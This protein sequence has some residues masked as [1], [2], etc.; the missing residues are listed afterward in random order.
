MAQRPKKATRT[1]NP[2]KTRSLIINAALSLFQ[3]QGFTETSISDIV[4]KA[5]LTK[6]AFYHHFDT[7]E[8]ILL[9][10]HDE[11]IEHQL[12]EARQILEDHDDPKEQLVLMIHSMINAIDKYNANVAIFFQERRFLQGKSFKHV[13]RDRDELG[14]LFRGIVARGVE[15]GVFRKSIDPAI[16]TFGILG[17]C[18]WTYQWYREDGRMSAEEIAD[19]FAEIALSGIQ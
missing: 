14:E 7:K 10:I 4:E 18:A 13:R 3:K 6:G 11:Y 16:A 19:S 15:Q 1:Y 5:G 2:E 17:M 8:A 12:S 9:L